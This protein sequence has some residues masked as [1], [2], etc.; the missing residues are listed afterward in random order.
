MP[1]INESFDNK[2]FLS[3]IGGRIAQKVEEGTPG[4]KLRE[5]ETPSGV[6]GSKWEVYYPA[7]MGKIEDMRIH[8]SE[9]GDALHVVFEDC[10]LSLPVTQRYFSD[11]VKK[12]ASANLDLPV[13]IKPY[14]FVT[15]DG[16]RKSGLTLVQ[17]ETKLSDHF[18]NFET[19]KYSDGFPEPGDIKSKDEWKIYFMQVNVFLKN[20]ILLHPIKNIKQEEK[21]LDEVNKEIDD[22]VDSEIE[23]NKVPF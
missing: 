14:D 18:Y 19:K 20:W 21:S 16:K 15:D 22:V 2:P 1:A 10:I 7:W 6:K 9:Y 3:I 13:T 5:Y 17:G 11:F 23:L 8:E 4:A 12:I